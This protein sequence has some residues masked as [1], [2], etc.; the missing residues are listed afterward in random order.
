MINAIVVHFAISLNWIKAV[1][2]FRKRATLKCR[3]KKFT[4]AI[5][6]VTHNTFLY[7]VIR[8]WKQARLFEGKKKQWNSQFQASTCAASALMSAS[9][10]GCELFK[11]IKQ[12]KKRRS[13]PKETMMPLARMARSGSALLYHGTGRE[14]STYRKTDGYITSA[15]RRIM[16]I[17]SR[18]RQ[19]C[20]SILVNKRHVRQS[21]LLFHFCATRGHGLLIKNAHCHSF[22]CD[23]FYTSVSAS[24]RSEKEMKYY[25]SR[26]VNGAKCALFT[27]Q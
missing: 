27:Q 19:K 16:D 4:S 26:S 22:M 11:I 14:R 20:R 13:F 9:H 17:W 1:N 6:I 12:N 7:A 10:A 25:G 5:N 8:I 21:H 2:K 15:R 3:V 23:L 18:D 24:I